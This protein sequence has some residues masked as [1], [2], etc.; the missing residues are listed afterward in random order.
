[1]LRIGRDVGRLGVH[2][3]TWCGCCGD[4]S[5]IIS[6]TGGVPKIGVDEACCYFYSISTQELNE[7]HLDQST[8][9]SLEETP[10]VCT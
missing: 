3:R 5:K 7:R 4:S 6:L 10:I 8:V 1:M 9:H 2:Q